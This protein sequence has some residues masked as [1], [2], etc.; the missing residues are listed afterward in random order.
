MLHRKLHKIQEAN[1]K[2]K[3]VEIEVPIINDGRV[4][5]ISIFHNNRMMKVRYH[6]CLFVG[7]LVYHP[8]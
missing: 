8:V 1:L 3:I 7:F 4:Q 5:F 2:T 6:W